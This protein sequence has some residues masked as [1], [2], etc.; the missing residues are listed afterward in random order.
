MSYC[1]HG[2]AEHNMPDNYFFTNQFL[3]IAL[4]NGQT[5]SETKAQHS[6]TMFPL[7]VVIA[8]SA[9]SLSFQFERASCRD[10]D[11]CFVV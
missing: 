6:S 4:T 11:I 2:F 1:K 8:T 3:N 7:A 9:F 5:K 10:T